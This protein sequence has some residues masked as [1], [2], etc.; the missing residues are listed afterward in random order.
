MRLLRLS[1]QWPSNSPYQKKCGLASCWL[2]SR[3]AISAAWADQVYSQKMVTPR[4]SRPR[5]WR[6]ARCWAHLFGRLDGTG[7]Y[8]D[9]QRWGHRAKEHSFQIILNGAL[10]LNPD[11]KSVT[12]DVEVYD[13]DLFFTDTSTIE[14]C[15]GLTRPLSAASVPEPTSLA[16]RTRP[17][18]L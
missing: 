11:A 9:I 6:N 18:L 1:G 2:F 4:W 5:N 15:I 7:L 14:R 12:P 3:L 13:I 8:Q 16:G 10:D 17:S